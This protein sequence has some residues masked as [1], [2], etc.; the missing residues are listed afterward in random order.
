MSLGGGGGAGG[1]GGIRMAWDRFK[2]TE[3]CLK[4][5]NVWGKVSHYTK[6]VNCTI[7]AGFKYALTQKIVILNMGLDQLYMYVT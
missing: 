2:L 5:T 3:N 4:K 6:A 7:C 1:G